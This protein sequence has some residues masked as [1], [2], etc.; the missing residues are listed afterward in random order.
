MLPLLPFLDPRQLNQHIAT[1]MWHW[2]N[3][4]RTRDVEGF[5]EKKNSLLTMP[6]DE[7]VVCELLGVIFEV[8][9]V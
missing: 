1:P 3:C 6:D 8:V 9:Q 5:L 7:K 4:N 2:Q